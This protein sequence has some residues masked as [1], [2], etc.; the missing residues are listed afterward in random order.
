MLWERPQ[1]HGRRGESPHGHMGIV[2]SLEPDV[3][4]YVDIYAVDW[5]VRPGQSTSSEARA[6]FVE[7]AVPLPAPRPSHGDTRGA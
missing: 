6:D 3:P 1:F 2:L 4:A 7:H 5:S